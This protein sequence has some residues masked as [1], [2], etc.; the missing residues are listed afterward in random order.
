MV[1]G[2]GGWGRS[3]IGILVAIYMYIPYSENFGDLAMKFF[4]QCQ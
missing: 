1:G 4:E 2:G 3:M